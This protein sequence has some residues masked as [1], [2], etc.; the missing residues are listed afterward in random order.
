MPSRVLS[1]LFSEYTDTKELINVPALQK[2]KIRHR[3]EWISP[4][5]THNM[6]LNISNPGLVSALALISEL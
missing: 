1:W 6:C 3:D 5:R 2:V 4:P